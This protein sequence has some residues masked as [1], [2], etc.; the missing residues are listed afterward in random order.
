MALLIVIVGKVRNLKS[1]IYQLCI[2]SFPLEYLFPDNIVNGSSHSDA[3]T[4]PQPSIHCSCSEIQGN[5][6]THSDPT[7]QNNQ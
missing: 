7:C 3:A 4:I 5:C 6:G 1:G 2:V